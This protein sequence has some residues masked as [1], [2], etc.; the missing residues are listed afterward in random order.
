MNAHSQK[1]EI[2]RILAEAKTI[3]VVGLSSRPTRAGHYVPA[4]L[5]EAGYR[6]IPVNPNLEEALGEKAYPDLGAIPDPVDLVLIFQRSENVPPF[7]DQAIEI[8]ARAVWMQLGIANEAAAQKARAAGLQVVQ[9]ACMM[10]EHRHWY[11]AG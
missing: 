8:G 11:R 1:H 10:V 2:N 4:Y 6:I 5:Q 9:N 7:V 3:A